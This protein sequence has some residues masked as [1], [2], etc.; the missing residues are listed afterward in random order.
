MS[1]T[2][3]WEGPRTESDAGSTGAPPSAPSAPPPGGYRPPP[4]PPPAYPVTPSVP[5]VGQP[6]RRSSGAITCL[7]ILVVLAAIMLGGMA[8]LATGLRSTGGPQTTWA[9]ATGDTIGVISVEGIITG[10]GSI[11]PFFG[12]TAGSDN[13][14]ALFREAAKD[15]VVKAIVLRIDSPGGSAAASQEIYEAVED[16]RQRTGKPV[17]ASM[18]DV[19]ASGGYYVAA[20]CSKIVALPATLTGSIGVIFETLEYHEL[21]K[22]VGVKGNTMTSGPHKDM[23]SPFRAMT[24][25]ERKLFEAMIEDVYDQFVTAVADGR[26]M[27]KA[28]VKKLADGRVYT[29][30]QAK[31]IGLVDELGSFRG[32]IK[33]AAEMARIEKEPTV[34]F[35]GRMTLFEAL[36]GEVRSQPIRNFPPGL[37][38]DSR[39]WPVGQ[40]MMTETGAPRLE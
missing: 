20:P 29:G 3:P 31:E 6:R 12:A 36:F 17:V 18:S 2:P 25:E 19:A 33:I 9:G 22:K 11:S 30:R 21:L 27:D 7:I 26:K 5:P 28:K 10:G 39:V 14:T 34:K 13:I 1:T 15:D 32:A 8:L 35:Y 23:G 40:M 24:G 38:F 16:Y 4:G 37:L